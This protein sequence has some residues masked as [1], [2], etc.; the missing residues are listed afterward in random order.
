MKKS[1][2]S[3]GDDGKED[4]WRVVGYQLPPLLIP[5]IIRYTP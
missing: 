5:E 2:W 1:K 4:E 3:D